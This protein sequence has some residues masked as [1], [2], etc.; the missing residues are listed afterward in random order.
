L[1]VRMRSHRFHARAGAL[2]LGSGVLAWMTLLGP[3]PDTAEAAAFGKRT[4]R[5]GM[6]GS[7][8]RTLQRYLTRAGF[9]TTADGQ[10]GSRTERSV[11]RFERGEERRVNGVVSP[12]DARA[13]LLVVR[14]AEQETTTV[15]PPVAEASLTSD[16]MAVAPASAPPEVAAVIE[17]G[18]RI[19]DKPYRY[20]G[21]HGRWKDTGYDCSGSVSYALH[22]GGLLDRPLDSTGLMSWG[23]R[24]RGAWITVYA[25]RA[26]AY[27]VVAGLRFDTSARKRSGT[28]WSEAMRSPRTYSA[29]HPSGF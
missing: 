12:A 4:L 28:R 24:G 18:N 14:E 21:G 3:A 2:W 10:F 7:D 6:S 11:K 16:G 19:A 25:N 8:V 15:Q 5:E 1:V 27:M 23:D 17:A 22:G 13:L 26:H 20:G 9:D 29:R